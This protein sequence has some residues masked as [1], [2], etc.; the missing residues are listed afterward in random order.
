MPKE[1]KGRTHSSATND[2]DDGAALVRTHSSATN[3]H[4]DGAA[5]VRAADTYRNNLIIFFERKKN[6][7]D[8]LQLLDLEVGTAENALAAAEAAAVPGRDEW[9]EE[10]AAA[11]TAAAA[12]ATFD[13]SDKKV[14]TLRIQSILKENIISETRELDGNIAALYKSVDALTAVGSMEDFLEQQNKLYNEYYD[15]IKPSLIEAIDNLRKIAGQVSVSLGSSGGDVVRLYN[16]WVHALYAI[17][18]P[19]HS[20]SSMPMTSEV[21]K[22]ISTQTMNVL[23]KFFGWSQFA[24][25][26][27]ELVKPEFIGVFIF[28]TT[29]MLIGHTA[30]TRAAAARAAAEATRAANSN[31][32][33]NFFYRAG[34]VGADSLSA[35]I[36]ATMTLVNGTVPKPYWL[37]S[38]KKGVEW[39]A[40]AL[41][42]SANTVGT[43]RGIVVGG[44][45][46]VKDATYAQLAVGLSGYL[47]VRE[48][49]V[50]RVK[51]LVK[52]G[53]GAAA[54]EGGGTRRSK[55]N[56]HKTKKG[57]KK[58]QRKKTR[59]S[60]SKKRRSGSRKRQK[61]RSKHS[62]TRRSKM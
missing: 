7:T 36:D 15:I 11:E 38:Y 54:G 27:K 33:T 13:S 39:A 20:L 5:L 8:I 21:L 62:P 17:E 44:H 28:I 41:G 6:L 2:H 46:A 50:R 61:G 47:T 52:W 32:V 22:Q 51:D 30:A 37:E 55:A 25:K 34:N 23:N 29:L 4:G 49:A 53:R 12:A 10:T 18:R 3:D 48:G 24:S 60:A 19:D 26:I 42:L 1:Y 58:K 14:Q 9:V 16:N 59:S 35:A 40:G 45:G 56:R 57:F 31:F 43:L